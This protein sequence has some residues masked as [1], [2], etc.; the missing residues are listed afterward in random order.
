MG[1]SG[2]EFMD[3]VPSVHSSAYRRQS[4]SIPDT[5]PEPMLSVGL[6]EFLNFICTKINNQNVPHYIVDSCV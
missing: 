2:G 3:V 1:K 6:Y 5:F 4:Q